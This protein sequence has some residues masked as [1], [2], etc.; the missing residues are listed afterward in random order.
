MVLLLLVVCDRTGLEELGG[1]G[2]WLG[3][4]MRVP[5]RWSKGVKVHLLVV[6]VGV[7]S[8]RWWLIS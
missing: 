7:I 4:L 5:T 6:D 8:Q 2:Q 1:G 3:V